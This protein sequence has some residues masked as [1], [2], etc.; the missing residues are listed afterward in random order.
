MADRGSLWIGALVIAAG[1]LGGCADEENG[2]ADAAEPT[3][4]VAFVVDGDTIHVDGGRRIRLVQ[5]DAPEVDECYARAATRALRRLLPA[6][7][8]VTLER[9]RTLDDVDDYGRLL[10]Y[11]V[12]GTRNVNVE[13][14]RLGAAVPYFF[15]GER[16]VLAGRLLDAARQARRL[17]RGLWAACPAARLDPSRGSLTGPV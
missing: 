17:R 3:A 11:V 12:S 13:L 1:G 15:R 8:T 6:G 7:A 9:D 14:V 5:I 16:G 10:R 4:R 2:A